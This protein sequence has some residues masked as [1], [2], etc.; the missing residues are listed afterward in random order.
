M[1]SHTKQ[2]LA[3]MKLNGFILALEEQ[4]QQKLSGLSFEERLSFL[5]EKEFM[6]RENKQ[7][8]NR[9]KAAKL[10][11]GRAEAIDFETKR[12]IRREQLLSLCHLGWVTQHRSI[13]ITGPTGTGKTFIACS[14]ANKACIA[15]HQ[16]RYFRLLHFMHE[17]TVASREHRLQRFLTGLNKTA[18]LVLDDFGLMV[19]DEEQ[20]HLLLEVLEQRYE[21]ASTIITSQLP[22]EDWYE[23]LND[24]V[25]ADA[26]L[27]RIVHQSERIVLKGESLR[28]AKAQGEGEKE[29]CKGGEKV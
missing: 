10:K 20:R 15:G 24:P 6:Y 18:V 2:Q 4:E 11:P 23:H 28:K 26:L 27:D 1:L 7:R 13:I 29:T 22:V 25:I 12:G 9:L 21:T 3:Q 5:V 14:L 16:T 17:V 8:E 19:L